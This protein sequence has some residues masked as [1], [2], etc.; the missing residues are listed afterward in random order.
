MFFNV[1]Q[2]TSKVAYFWIILQKQLF[3]RIQIIN[4][5]LEFSRNL[6]HREIG[7]SQFVL[8]VSSSIT[9]FVVTKINAALLLICFFLSLMLVLQG[10]CS[11]I[12]CCSLTYKSENLTCEWSKKTIQ[13]SLPYRFFFSSEV[14]LSVMRWHSVVLPG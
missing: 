4:R 6:L 1:I 9:N 14:H 3:F 10:I 13:R 2:Q 5:L 12:P 8:K 11:V 7:K